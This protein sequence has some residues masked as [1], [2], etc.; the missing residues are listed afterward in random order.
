IQMK[1]FHLHSFIIFAGVAASGS[2]EDEALFHPRGIQQFKGK[3]TLPFRLLFVEPTDKK[4]QDESWFDFTKLESTSVGKIL[5]GANGLNE[6]E[7]ADVYPLNFLQI[8]SEPITMRLY[9]NPGP[10][11]VARLTL[12]IMMQ[13]TD[14]Q[15]N[16]Q[17]RDLRFP[18]STDELLCPK[19]ERY[20][21]GACHYRRGESTF[22]ELVLP[23]AGWPAEA[24]GRMCTVTLM[25]FEGEKKTSVLGATFFARY[26]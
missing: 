26:D 14:D 3:S 11:H 20:E 12:E 18:Q 7:G 19:A 15:G 2:N 25:L 8:G 5:M 23:T 4:N 16:D 21:F 6:T 13:Y 24:K 22:E 9:F 10:R 17:L 1:V